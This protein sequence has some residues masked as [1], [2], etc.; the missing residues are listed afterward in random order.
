MWTPTVQEGGGTPTCGDCCAA[1]EGYTQSTI[2]CDPGL[3]VIPESQTQEDDHYSAAD[4]HRSDPSEYVSK[5]MVG[6]SFPT[7]D[8][9]P[10]PEHMGVAM[11]QFAKCACLERK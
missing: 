1:R 6:D 5:Q 10:S 4:A 11:G 8:R 3:P 9:L 2:P 7:V